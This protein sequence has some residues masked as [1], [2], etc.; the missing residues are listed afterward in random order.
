MRE[1]TDL[2]LL[3]VLQK[4][5]TLAQKKPI[6]QLSFNVWLSCGQF[7]SV[8]ITYW[9]CQTSPSLQ[10]NRPLESPTLVAQDVSAHFAGDILEALLPQEGLKEE[11]VSKIVMCIGTKFCYCL[12]KLQIF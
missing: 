1:W 8:L 7:R 10:T 2:K 4:S 11:R 5:L 12:Q 6:L 3:C 9:D